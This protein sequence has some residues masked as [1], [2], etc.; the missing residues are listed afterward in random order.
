MEYRIGLATTKNDVTE[1][2]QIKILWN[3]FES[4]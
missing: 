2:F 3:F 4:S 1:Q